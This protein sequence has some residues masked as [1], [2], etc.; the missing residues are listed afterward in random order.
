MN[1]NTSKSYTIA[2]VAGEHSG[3][4]YG[5]AII[6]QLQQKYP[7]CTFV[8]VGGPRMI[9]SGL[10][11]LM[12]IDLLSVVGIFNVIKSLPKLIKAKNKL[13]ADFINL[14]PDLFIG[15]DAPE[16]NLAVAKSLRK[17]IN[18]NKINTKIIQY[19]SPTI[20][21]W[22]KRRVFTVKK[23]VDKVLCIFP[24][25]KDIYLEKKISAS[26][27][28][29]PLANKLGPVDSNLKNSAI[30]KLSSYLDGTNISSKKII[31]VF[32]GSRR[33][34][35]ESLSKP[36]IETLG[37]LTNKNNNYLFIVPIV[38]ESLFQIWDK[39][40]N[41]YI[42]NYNISLPVK[43]IK[44]YNQQ[45]AY[46]INSSDIMYL[47]DLIL[48][49]SGTTTLE[50]LLCNIPMVVAYKVSFLNALLIRFLI[51]VKHIAM[52]N[53][54]SDR[55][56]GSSLVP[57]FVQSDVNAEQLSAA[58]LRELDK[59]SLDNP[60]KNILQ[61]KWHDLQDYLRSGELKHEQAVIEEISNVIN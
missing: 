36:F 19:I 2:I 43:V 50:A 31:G 54:L 18:N 32:P 6:T 15:V 39:H 60:E 17:H 21:I 26:F 57:E 22:R 47:S 4:N 14:K 59:Y 25:E 10:K 9:D 49:A 58:I 34:E 48:C 16:F 30:S 52:A 38:N 61:K 20:W 5:A 40:Y 56:F 33:S 55:L 1:N 11:S 8:G 28:G 27:V 37:F 23:A 24:F 3:D 53:I 45:G 13:V 29:H 51:K 46:K 42:T 41:E 12:P 7:N 35:L 44:L